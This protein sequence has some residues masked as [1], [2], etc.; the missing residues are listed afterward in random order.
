VVFAGRGANPNKR[1]AFAGRHLVA[2]SE[3][4]GETAQ[5]RHEQARNR[6]STSGSRRVGTFCARLPSPVRN[7][8]AT[9]SI[10]MKSFAVK[11]LTRRGRR[12]HCLDVQ[13]REVTHVDDPEAEPRQPADDRATDRDH[14]HRTA[15]AC[16]NVGRT[17]RRAGSS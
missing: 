1:R 6:T 14:L 3:F 9:S 13:V 12:R 10:H 8:F 7:A 16:I 5:R 17:P 4:R 2:T 11:T 15:I